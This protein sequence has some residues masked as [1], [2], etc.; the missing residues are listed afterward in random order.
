VRADEQK[1][2]MRRE[3]RTSGRV[4]AKSVSIK[5]AKRKSSGCARK[6]IELTSGGLHRVSETRLRESQGALITVQKSAEGVV[7][8]AQS[9]RSTETLTRKGRNGSGSHDRQRQG[10]RPERS[11]QGVEGSGK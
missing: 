11:P 3:R 7:R 9:V 4:P 2:D 5:G 1:L 10:G 8:R 6:V